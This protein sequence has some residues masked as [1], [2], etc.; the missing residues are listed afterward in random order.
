ML[1]GALVA[2][3]LAAANESPAVAN[4]V[5]PPPRSEPAVA[6]PVLAPAWL[7][8]VVNTVP[9]GTVLVQLSGADA[10]IAAE[11]LER[12]GV[13]L[14]RGERIERAGRSLVSLASLAPEVTFTV[15]EVG[16]A[17]RVVAAQ[18]VLGR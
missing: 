11:D 5:A 12:A 14:D 9:K 2:I 8:L 17:V 1:P 3:L 15:D 4:A 10:W 7:D 16:L 6:M 13:R 18:A